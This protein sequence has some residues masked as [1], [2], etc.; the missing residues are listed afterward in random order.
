M[1]ECVEK[2]ELLKIIKR[3]GLTPWPRLF[4]TLRASCE[5][6]LLAHLPMHAMA[7]WL[8]HSAAVALKHYTR[9]PEGLYQ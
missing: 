5:T 6:D 1:I 3:G 9:I 2:P 4:H 8:R 7:A